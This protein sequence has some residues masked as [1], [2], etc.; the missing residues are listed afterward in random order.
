MQFYNLIEY[1]FE[2]ESFFCGSLF[3]LMEAPLDHGGGFQFLMEWCCIFW[4][5]PPP[6][7]CIR[8]R[9]GHVVYELVYKN[10]VKSGEECS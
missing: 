9:M 1:V 4:F 7:S 6:I 3:C 10:D 8:G 5:G 2:E